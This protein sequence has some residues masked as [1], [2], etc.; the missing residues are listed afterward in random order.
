MAMLSCAKGRPQ[1]C[2]RTSPLTNI[3]ISRDRYMISTKGMLAVS[4]TGRP[5]RWYRLQPSGGAGFQAGESKLGVLLIPNSSFQTIA[6]WP[7]YCLRPRNHHEPLRTN[8]SLKPRL[9]NTLPRIPSR[10]QGVDL[11]LSRSKQTLTNARFS[12][13]IPS[14]SLAIN[15]GFQNFRRID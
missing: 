14:C 4:N 2:C 10:P 13:F 3:I 5:L 8:E 7:S 1:Y 12:G 15:Q 6:S 9:A 11:A